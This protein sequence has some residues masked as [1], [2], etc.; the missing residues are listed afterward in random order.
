[1]DREIG[2]FISTR[3]VSIDGLFEKNV[4]VYRRVNNKLIR[5]FAELDYSRESYVDG[6]VYNTQALY[7][8]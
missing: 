6:E 4:K 7:I 3:R 5:K 2:R 1:M 8:F